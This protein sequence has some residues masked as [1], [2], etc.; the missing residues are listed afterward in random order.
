[1]N[2]PPK[3]NAFSLAILK[4]AFKCTFSPSRTVPI[5]GSFGAISGTTKSE[6]GEPAEE[7]GMKASKALRKSSF[8]RTFRFWGLAQFFFL[9]GFGGAGSA[10]PEVG[11]VP[12]GGLTGTR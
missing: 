10:C 4:F 2:F 1:M 6:D 7:E 11:I 3:P 12:V 9:L 5:W 8:E